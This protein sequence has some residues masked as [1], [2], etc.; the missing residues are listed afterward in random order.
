MSQSQGPSYTVIAAI[1]LGTS[2]SGYAVAYTTNTEKSDEIVLNQ[3]HV[4]D[5]ERHSTRKIPSHILIQED[6]FFGCFGHDAKRKYKQLC[7]KQQHRE[8]YYF[9]NI[10]KHLFKERVNT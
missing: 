10:L 1:D 7:L 8:A 6:D 2:T 4:S 3:W 5:D 9:K